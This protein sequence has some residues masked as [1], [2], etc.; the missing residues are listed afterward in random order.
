MS[1]CAFLR[2]SPD[3]QADIQDWLPPRRL[4]WLVDEPNLLKP[5]RFRFAECGADPVF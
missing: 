5:S 1:P 3:H 2:I 4:L